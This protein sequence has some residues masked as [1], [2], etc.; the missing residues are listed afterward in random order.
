MK[1]ALVILFVLVALIVS[2]VPVSSAGGNWGFR[3]V[4]GKITRVSEETSSI[5]VE[6]NC[7][8]PADCD[9]INL[10]VK[11]STIINITGEFLLL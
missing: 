10:V 8:F 11:S 3:F 5:G 2:V 7:F 4:Q 1:K 9:G 6:Y